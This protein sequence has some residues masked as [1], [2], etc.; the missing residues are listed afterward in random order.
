MVDAAAE[1]V[2]PYAFAR[3]HFDQVSMVR[4]VQKTAVSRAV[5]SSSTRSWTYLSALVPETVSHGPVQDHSNS[6]S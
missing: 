1:Q 2:V 5:R 3:C 4:Q 6:A